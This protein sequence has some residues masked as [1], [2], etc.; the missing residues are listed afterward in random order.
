[1]FS[2]VI[3][4]IDKTLSAHPFSNKAIDLFRL[5]PQ[6][7]VRSVDILQR[8]VRDI[9]AHL[10]HNLICDNAVPQSPD[11]QGRALDIEAAFDAQKGL[12]RLVVSRAVAV[13]VACEQIVSFGRSCYRKSKHQLFDGHLTW[14]SKTMPRVLFDIVVKLI[15]A[16]K[17]RAFQR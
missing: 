14:R 15:L 3:L 7:P 4:L 6:Q 17:R 11:K 13:V 5:L 10:G 1:M 9:V 8:Q 2:T 16:H 12:V